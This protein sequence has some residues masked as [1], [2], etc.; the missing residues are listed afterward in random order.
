MPDRRR[1]FSDIIGKMDFRKAATGQEEG[2]LEANGGEG[3][4][5]KLI[6]DEDGKL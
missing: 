1:I 2:T 4:Q 5:M 6:G 3:D